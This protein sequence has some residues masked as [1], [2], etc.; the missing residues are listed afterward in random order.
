MVPALLRWTRWDHDAP[1][2]QLRDRLVV[3]PGSGGPHRAAS[4]P[5]RHLR[6]AQILDF[7][8]ERAKRV[9]GEAPERACRRALEMFH[10]GQLNVQID[11]ATGEIVDVNPNEHA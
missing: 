3:R 5:P 2:R 11:A 6:A 9:G 7:V 1:W 8:G 4:N 10:A